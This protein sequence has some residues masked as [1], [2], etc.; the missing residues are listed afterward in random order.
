MKRLMRLLPGPQALFVIG[1]IVVA[2]L[3]LAWAVVGASWVQTLAAFA[4]YYLALALFL[5]RGKISN[6]VFGFTLIFGMFT[7]W[8]GVPLVALLLRLVG[9]L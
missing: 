8:L 4:I 1:A 7:A 2:P 6:E 9:L 5:G 3:A